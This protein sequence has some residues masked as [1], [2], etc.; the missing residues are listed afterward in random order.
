[1]DRS[2]ERWSF[3]IRL[4]PSEVN[5]LVRAEGAPHE[6]FLTMEWGLRL[7]HL[8]SEI[9]C[10]QAIP[11]MIRNYLW[12]KYKRQPAEPEIYFNMAKWQVGLG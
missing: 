5:D 7:F 4:S 6:G 8:H 1:M 11:F 12:L 9:I 10:A 3:G 2:T